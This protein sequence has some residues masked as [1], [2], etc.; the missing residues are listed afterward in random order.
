MIDENGM[1]KV[2]GTID[3]GSGILLDGMNV[4][5]II[6]KKI[7]KKLF[8]PKEAVVQRQ[9]KSVVF[10]YKDNHAIWRYIVPETENSKFV[11]ISEGLTKGDEV[12]TT[13]VMNLAN[14][15]KVTIN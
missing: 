2:T 9:N 1:V 3:N 6:R 10:V 13:N 8:I 14:N 12:I 5:V 7:P 11:V 15:S 4:K